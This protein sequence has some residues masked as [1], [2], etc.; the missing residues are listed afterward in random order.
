M[1]HTQKPGNKRY[2]AAKSI[3]PTVLDTWRSGRGGGLKKNFLCKGR[4]GPSLISTRRDRFLFFYAFPP[5]QRMNES[6]LN[7]TLEGL[8]R[9][10]GQV[11]FVLFEGR[12]EGHNGQGYAYFRRFS[13]TSLS[14][15]AFDFKYTL[16]RISVHVPLWQCVAPHPKKK[17]FFIN[18]WIP[19][20]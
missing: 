15:P 7:N 3:I 14:I 10:P 20:I 5:Q 13:S 8:T 1:S 19:F 16:S 2:F 12:F 4:C 18:Y 11:S 9:F 17:K 6:I